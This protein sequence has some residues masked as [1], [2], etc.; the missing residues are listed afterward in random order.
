M[1]CR[2]FFTSPAI[3][4]ILGVQ[5]QWHRIPRCSFSE[6]FWL[7]TT[8]VV[9]FVNQ[10]INVFVLRLTQPCQTRQTIALFIHSSVCSM[11]Y[12]QCVSHALLGDILGYG[13]IKLSLSVL[14]L[15]VYQSSTVLC[16]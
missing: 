11:I 3:S 14:G 9:Y 1:R 6:F 5:F 16:N 10:V 2:S 8:K 15:P 7:L 13:N 4:V 12:L